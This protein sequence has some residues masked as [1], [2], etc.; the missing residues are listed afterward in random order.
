[1]RLAEASRH[2]SL[3]SHSA[4]VLSVRIHLRVSVEVASR[5]AERTTQVRHCRP[6]SHV[7]LFLT[8]CHA[9][10]AKSR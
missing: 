6:A 5:V 10:F 9:S 7:H 3:D 8:T 2:R 4:E 1:M